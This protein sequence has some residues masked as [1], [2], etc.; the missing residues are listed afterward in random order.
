MTDIQKQYSQEAIKPVSFGSIFSNHFHVNSVQFSSHSTANKS[1]IL[2]SAQT[3]D[4]PF[5]NPSPG[6]NNPFIR[7][8]APCLDQ[9][10]DIISPPIITKGNRPELSSLFDY[11]FEDCLRLY[12]DDLHNVS[13]KTLLH[14]LRQDACIPNH[15]QSLAN[16]YLMLDNDLMHT[17]CE[18][19]F[20]QVRQ[21]DI[22]DMV[23]NRLLSR[24]TKRTAGTTIASSIKLLLKPAKLATHKRI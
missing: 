20:I 13:A 7:F 11:E 19:I 15:L 22:A 23:T 17:F 1:A 5:V 16:I 6:L 8:G 9:R 2:E 18:T 3:I 21:I 4:T 10:Q 12:I 24:W 14:T